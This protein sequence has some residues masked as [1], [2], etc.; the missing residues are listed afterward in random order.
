MLLNGNLANILSLWE[1]HTKKFFGFRYSMYSVTKN[2]NCPKSETRLG[3]NSADVHLGTTCVPFALQCNI[4]LTTRPTRCIG[5]TNQL[6]SVL[7][8]KAKV[9]T[10]AVLG[11]VNRE[12]LHAVFFF[13]IYWR[14]PHSRC[15]NLW[16]T[17]NLKW[18]NVYGIIKTKICCVI[19]SWR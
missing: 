11:T 16:F 13:A 7:Q 3:Q 10:T 17:D 14:N 18:S 6:F 8:S 19:F 1:P 9:S 2:W 12:I 5:G 4:C 15:F